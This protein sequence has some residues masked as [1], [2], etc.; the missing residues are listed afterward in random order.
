MVVDDNNLQLDALLLQD[1]SQCLID[2]FFFI[3]SRDD[4]TDFGKVGM[5]ICWD[6]S[7][8]EIAREL[9][10]KGAEVILMPIWG[11]NE[12][13]CRRGRSRIRF[14]WSSAVMTCAAPSTT[15]PVKPRRSRPI[16]RAPSSTPT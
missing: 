7:Y 13:L 6:V 12:T 16:R 3:P 4:D 15:R 1:R 10:A 14:R 5:M 11:G 8:P 9:T 2:V